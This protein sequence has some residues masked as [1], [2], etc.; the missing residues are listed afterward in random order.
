MI[1]RKEELR[2]LKR[3]DLISVLADNLPPNTVRFGC[4]VHSVK[5]NPGT[6]SPVL[7]LQDGTILNP[8]VS[9]D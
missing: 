9:N 8:K 4:E 3:T 2:V 5:L 7:Q 1:Y 6:S